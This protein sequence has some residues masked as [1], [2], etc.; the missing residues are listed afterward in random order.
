M[1]LHARTHCCPLLCLN[2]Y[3]SPGYTIWSWIRS[4]RPHCSIRHDKGLNRRHRH[5]CLQISLLDGA[6]HVSRSVIGTVALVQGQWSHPSWA[7]L[8]WLQQRIT[9]CHWCK[10]KHP[11]HCRQHEPAC[12]SGQGRVILFHQQ[13]WRDRRHRRCYDYHGHVSASG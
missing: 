9:A 11:Y 6:C 1:S 4:S 3:G 7:E 12:S 10:C 5:V 8:Q 13:H 2:S